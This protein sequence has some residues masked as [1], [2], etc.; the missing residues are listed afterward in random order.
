M[1][2]KTH[3]LDDDEDNSNEASRPDDD[4]DLIDDEGGFFY[5]YCFDLNNNVLK[6]PSSFDVWNLLFSVHAGNAIKR[7]LSSTRL[8]PEVKH[9]KKTKS[10]VKEKALLAS[11]A[12]DDSKRQDEAVKYEDC[13]FFPAKCYLFLCSYALRLQR[14]SLWNSWIFFCIIV[15]GFLVGVQTYDGMVTWFL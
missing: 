3:A 11:L 8:K 7:R 1:F 4:E 6:V 12:K 13:K 15:A 10:K 14:N 2:S 9:K 5:K